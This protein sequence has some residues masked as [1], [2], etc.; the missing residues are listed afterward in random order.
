MNGG[1]RASEKVRVSCCVMR[2]ALAASDNFISTKLI[3]ITEAVPFKVLP[4]PVWSFGIDF[5]VCLL[6]VS[7]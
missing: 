3:D 4:L 6:D 7:F 2:L 5:R 1:G